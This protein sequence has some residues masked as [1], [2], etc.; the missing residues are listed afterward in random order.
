MDMELTVPE[1]PFPVNCMSPFFGCP[2]YVP[3][4]CVIVPVISSGV[5]KSANAIAV[6]VLDDEGK[7]SISDM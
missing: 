7:G 1:L 4:M 2:L 5:A 3:L 6:K